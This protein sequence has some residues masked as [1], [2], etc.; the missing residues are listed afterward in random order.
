MSG[1]Y[2]LKCSE[3]TSLPVFEDPRPG[4][5]MNLLPEKDKKNVTFATSQVSYKIKPGTMVFFPSYLPHQ[6]IVDV[7]YEPFRFIHWNCQAIPKGVLN[8]V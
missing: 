5:L 6:Y 3:R 2:F 8:V 7:G 4:N 1:F